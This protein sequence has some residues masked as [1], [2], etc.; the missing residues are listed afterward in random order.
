[1]TTPT[2][3]SATLFTNTTMLPVTVYLKSGTTA[4]TELTIN[5]VA[6]LL[7]L[8]SQIVSIPLEPG[9]TVQFTYTVARHGP[10]SG[11]NTFLKS[12]LRKATYGTPSEVFP[13][14]PGHP[15]AMFRRLSGY[16]MRGLNA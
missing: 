2:I 4:P 16:G 8:I 10:G 9:G 13:A 14:A 1:V 7:P 6:A 15:D 3:A 11:T 12:A 5:G